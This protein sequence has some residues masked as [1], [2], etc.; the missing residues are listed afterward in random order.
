VFRKVEIR[1]RH[2]L[3]ILAE[4]LNF[5]GVGFPFHFSSLSSHVLKAG[6]FASGASGQKVSNE[7]GLAPP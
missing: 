6:V 3:D 1:H 5:A 2:A 4:E 7:P